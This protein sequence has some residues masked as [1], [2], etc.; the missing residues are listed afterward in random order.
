M[1]VLIDTN[2]ILD[3]LLKREPYKLDSEIIVKACKD[4]K[5]RG[6]MAAHSVINIFYILRK[7]YNTKERKSILKAF[8]TFI[9]IIDITNDKI[10]S[11]LENDD[12]SD[13]EDC[14]QDECAQFINAEYIITRNTKDFKS[15]KIKVIEPQ[16]FVKNIL[17]AF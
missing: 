7:V 4:N 5:I 15:S 9:T 8:S 12:F 3:Y 2:I 11:A 13:L 6:Y 1:K 10:I 17:K 14:L 16:N